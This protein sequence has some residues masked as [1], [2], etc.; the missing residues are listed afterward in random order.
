LKSIGGH[1]SRKADPETVF[2]NL[3]RDI[4]FI[5]VYHLRNKQLVAIDDRE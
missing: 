3:R 4:L 2:A 1:P 5:L